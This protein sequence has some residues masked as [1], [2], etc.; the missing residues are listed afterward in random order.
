MKCDFMLC[1]N[2]VKPLAFNGFTGFTVPIYQIFT[3]TCQRW[4][5]WVVGMGASPLGRGYAGGIRDMAPL[6]GALA[7]KR[8]EGFSPYSNPPKVISAQE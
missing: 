1:K 7:T 5:V 8:S 3:P 4:G 2:P 6:K